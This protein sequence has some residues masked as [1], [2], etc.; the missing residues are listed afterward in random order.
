MILVTLCCATLARLDVRQILDVMALKNKNKT[1]DSSLKIQLPQVFEK[2]PTLSEKHQ[3]ELPTEPF[4][5]FCILFLHI[6][7]DSF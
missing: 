2:L 1:R 5:V 6:Y 4:L 3:S 7:L